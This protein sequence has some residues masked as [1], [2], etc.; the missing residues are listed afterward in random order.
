MCFFF[1]LKSIQQTC[2]QQ[3]MQNSVTQWGRSSTNVE[4][5]ERT[6]H[7]RT[8][9][10]C[11]FAVYCIHTYIYIC[12]YWPCRMTDG[13][14]VHCLRRPASFGNDSNSR[15][16]PNATAD[17][18]SCSDLRAQRE[19]RTRIAKTLYYYGVMSRKLIRSTLMRLTPIDR[20]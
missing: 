10:V 7:I 17:L 1:K 15:V 8:A 9:F 16:P 19:E 20:R 18:E 13:I 5:T 4:W 3:R 2:S 11:L 12:R 6:K 14:W